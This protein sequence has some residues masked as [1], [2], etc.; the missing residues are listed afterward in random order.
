MRIRIAGPLVLVQVVEVALDLRLDDVQRVVGLA[1]QVHADL[2]GNG[3]AHVAVWVAVLH[4]V[5]LCRQ[6]RVS[7]P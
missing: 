3:L 2:G 7:S 5:K 1:V 4:P 6:Q